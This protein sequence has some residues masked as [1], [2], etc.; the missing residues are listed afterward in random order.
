MRISGHRT[1]EVFERYN[2]TDAADL[3][4]AAQKQQVYLESQMV[5]KTV[6]I[7]DLQE[8]RVNQQCG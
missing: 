1:R 7:R 6:T 8:K 5:T 2:I 4:L 3:K